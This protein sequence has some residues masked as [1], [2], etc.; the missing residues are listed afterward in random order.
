MEVPVTFYPRAECRY[1]E[2]LTF[3]FNSCIQKQVEILGQGV[4]IKVRNVKVGYNTE[5]IVFSK[6]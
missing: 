3:L 1:H 6:T 4:Q 2:K 5:K